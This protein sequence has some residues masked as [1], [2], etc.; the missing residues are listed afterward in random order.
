MS[1]SKKERQRVEEKEDIINRPKHYTREGAM[2]C[3]DEMLEIFGVEAVEWFC[4]CNVWKYR[5][6]AADKNGSEDIKKSDWY[7]AK[8]RELKGSFSRRKETTGSAERTHNKI[9]QR[10]KGNEQKIY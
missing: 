2:E 9:L 1:A 8:Y 7:M 5:Y 3:I 10:S 6:R 4:L